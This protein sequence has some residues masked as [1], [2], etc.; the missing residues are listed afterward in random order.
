MW[1]LGHKGFG[2][3][4]LQRDSSKIVLQNALLNCNAK[5][6]DKIVLQKGSAKITLQKKS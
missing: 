3:I 4:V 5:G 6:S 1:S 2:K